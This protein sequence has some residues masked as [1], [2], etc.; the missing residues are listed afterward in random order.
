MPTKCWRND[1]DALPK[2][3][4]DMVMKTRHE[5]ILVANLKCYQEGITKGSRNRFAFPRGDW[6]LKKGLKHER[7]SPIFFRPSSSSLQ[8]ILSR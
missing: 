8:R 3:D 6:R 4:G 1:A 7:L 5:I 2:N